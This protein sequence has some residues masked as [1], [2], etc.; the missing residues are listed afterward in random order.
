VRILT[1]NPDHPKVKAEFNHP[2]VELVQGS[3]TDL[4]KVERALEGVWSAYINTDGFTVGEQAET[5]YGLRI[6]E[7]AA[8]VPTLKHYVW[9]NLD[10]GL[11]KPATVPNTTAGT[12]MARV[13]SA[14]GS[15]PSL[16]L[17][18]LTASS[19]PFSPTGPT[20]K[21]SMVATS[22]PRFSTMARASLQRGVRGTESP[23]SFD[24]RPKKP[25]IMCP[26]I[27]RKY[28]IKTFVEEYNKCCGPFEWTKGPE[29][30]RRI[31]AL[32]EQWQSQ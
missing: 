8:L 23:D 15:Q 14:T 17:L 25:R 26:F 6:F 2:N 5:Y 22:C 24:N 18:G 3:F 10:Y 7:L 12:T 21:C 27:R 32:T 11:K 4:A 28:T 13:E 16:S 31:I 19:G 30:L 1:R 29:K 20:P 9:S